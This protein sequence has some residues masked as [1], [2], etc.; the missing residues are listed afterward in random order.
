MWPL[1]GV[2]DATFFNPT[3]GLVHVAVGEPGLV[4]SV[5]TRTG[6]GTEFTTA[7]GAKTTALVAPD[8]LYVF[9]PSHH[10]ALGLVEA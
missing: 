3:S 1:A 8:S 7:K 6:T 2:P 9:S 4:H 10:G 5:N